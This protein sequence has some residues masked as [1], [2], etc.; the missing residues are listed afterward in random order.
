MN[1]G[2]GRRKHHEKVRCTLFRLIH[3]KQ[4]HSK[5][6]N[7][8]AWNAQHVQ[9]T[10]QVVTASLDLTRG[11]FLILMA[12]EPPLFLYMFV[13]TTR[14][15]TNIC[16]SFFVNLAFTFR[17][18][19]WYS[20]SLSSPLAASPAGKWVCRPQGKSCKR[21]QKYRSSMGRR[22]GTTNPFAVWNGL[23]FMDTKGVPTYR[24]SRNVQ[25]LSPYAS[26]W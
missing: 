24:K 13:S 25:H 20:S 4:R 7:I 19:A 3:N 22:V 21:C 10:R 18:V 12:Q 5:M 6:N 14:P 2:H 11:C 8:K 17:D 23:W 15:V 1:R 26:L 16:I 9:H